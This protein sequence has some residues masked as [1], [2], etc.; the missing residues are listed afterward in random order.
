MGWELVDGENGP[1]AVLP[2]EFVPTAVGFHQDILS[3]VDRSDHGA[4]D[5]VVCHHHDRA[6]SGFVEYG[7]E[8]GEDPGEDPLDRFG[9][10]SGIDSAPSAR[11]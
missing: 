6:A 4:D 3:G 7:V 8:G 2:R 1:L 10:G 9:P 5:G 11:G